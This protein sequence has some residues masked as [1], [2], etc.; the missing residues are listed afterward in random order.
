M[1]IPA[2]TSSV[3]TNSLRTVED[4]IATKIIHTGVETRINYRKNTV[5]AVKRT[6]KI[7]EM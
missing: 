4:R 7:R 5:K 3:E 1:K 2:R 6:D